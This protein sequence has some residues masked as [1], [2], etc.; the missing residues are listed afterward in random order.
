MITT[1]HSYSW[2]GSILILAAWHVWTGKPR[3][4]ASELV[5]VCDGPAFGPGCLVLGHGYA[6]LW[7]RPSDLGTKDVCWQ[8]FPS[9]AFQRRGFARQACASMISPVLHVAKPLEQQWAS[10]LKVQR[11]GIGGPHRG[12]LRRMG[13]W[14]GHTGR[15]LVH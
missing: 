7:P 6:M 14:R 13:E 8:V 4:P 10:K 12:R 9:R 3:R 5:D 2:C 15:L 11:T 1:T